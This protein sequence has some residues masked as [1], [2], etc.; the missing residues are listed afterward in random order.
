MT[1]VHAAARTPTPTARRGIGAAHAKAILVGE[2]AVVY[3][4]PAIAFPLPRLRIRAIAEPA[5]E[6]ALTCLNY[7]GPTRDAPAALRGIARAIAATLAVLGRPEQ[8]LHVTT[9]S[10]VPEARGLGSSAA[11]AAAVV[12]AVFDAFGCA[13]TPRE[14]FDLTQVS[15]RVAHG[16]PSGLDAAASAASGPIYFRAGHARPLGLPLAAPIVVADSGRPSGTLASVESVHR[17]VASAP[18][19]V[20]A[21]LRDLGGIAES[22]V[23]FLASGDL[24][25]LG[26]AM[27]AAQALLRQIGVSDAALDALVGA[28]RRAGALGAKLTGGGNGGCIIALSRGK[29]DALRV[30]AALRAAGARRTWVCEPERAA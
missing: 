9:R 17:L 18:A 28:A 23:R 5:P 24:R 27:D 4:Y 22:T 19:R 29:R 26:A 13:P 6:P 14:L 8:A 21:C 1:Q 30:S 16:H 7:A 12:R 25:S 10:D 2:H 11:A 3:G 15:E 20:R